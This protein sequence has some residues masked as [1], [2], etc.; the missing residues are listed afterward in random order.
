MTSYLGVAM[1]VTG[2]LRVFLKFWKKKLLKSFTLLLSRSQSKE[3][4]LKR[5]IYLAPLLAFCH[6]V[7]FSSNDKNKSRARKRTEHDL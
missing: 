5:I 4:E 3:L 1:S 6:H 2:I 7:L